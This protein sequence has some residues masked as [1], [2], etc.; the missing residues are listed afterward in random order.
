M[1][2]PLACQ[3]VAGRV[4]TRY[5]AYVRAVENQA[6]RDNLQL[7]R[8]TRGEH[9]ETRARWMLDRLHEAINAT[10]RRAS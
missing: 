1:S 10:S 3:D 8:E 9:P 2:A 4:A 7:A 5:G 6:I